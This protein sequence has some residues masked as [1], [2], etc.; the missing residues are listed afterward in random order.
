M[1]LARY[2][3]D[4]PA[5]VMGRR[6]LDLGAGSGLVAIAAALGGASQVIAA[7]VDRYAVAAAR[8]N[9][10]ANGVAVKVIADDLTRGPPPAVDL[11][12]VGDLFYERD[13]AER[14]TA[15]LDRC[16]SA[17]MDVVIGDPGRTYL[18]RSRLRHLADYRVPDVGEVEH[19]A[20]NASA[21][22]AL[23]P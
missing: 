14:V 11:V 7:D 2:I 10:A 19:A 17:G 3:L 22:F 20:T 16:L 9:A 8:L 6:V 21:V 13:L 5:T 23:E 15:F 18:P 4:R 12:A 1:A